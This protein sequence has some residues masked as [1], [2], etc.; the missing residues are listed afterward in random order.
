M[1]KRKR[2]VTSSP[3]RTGP[4]PETKAMPFGPTMS[5]PRRPPIAHVAGD[6]A[7]LA[8]AEK[9]AREMVNA[10]SEG[11]MIAEVPLDQIRENHIL[12]D[13]MSLDAEELASLKTSI[14]ARGQQ[15][16]IEV[17]ET[18]RGEYGLISGLRRLTALRALYEET[19]DAKFSHAK[20]LIKPLNS[21]PDAYI[22]MVEENEIRADLSFY[23]RARLA[24]EAAQQGVFETPQ[25]AVKALYAN[26]P[27]AKR[28]KIAAFIALHKAFGDALRFPAAIPEKLGLAL[29]KA[30]EGDK[31]FVVRLR[32]ALQADPPE[33]AE[34][35]R[36]VLD[37]ALKKPTASPVT[38]KAATKINPAIKLEPRG[39]GRITLSGEGVTDKFL[40]DLR[41][42]IASRDNSPQ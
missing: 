9:L 5:E 15:T 16:P 10:R 33:A 22:A 18:G 35:E 28:S 2:L 3:E 34:A 1:A 8:S 20:T 13:R 25:A 37:A 32:K 31:G 36:R 11:R 12:R 40:D 26:A 27:P 4:A 38:K 29:V 17:V 7:A 21:A 30:S 39:K 6:A 41:K 19:G 42:W 14:V 23:E 24:Y